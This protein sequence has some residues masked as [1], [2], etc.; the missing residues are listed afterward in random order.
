M[1][2]VTTESKSIITKKVVVILPLFDYLR[3]PN[4][5]IVFKYEAL[6][7]RFK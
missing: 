1:L 3:K 4:S 5:L 6:S 7:V 2:F